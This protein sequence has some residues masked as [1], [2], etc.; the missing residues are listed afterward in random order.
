MSAAQKTGAEQLADLARDVEAAVAGLGANAPTFQVSLF[1]RVGDTAPKVATW[2]WDEIVEKTRRPAVRAE[3]DGALFS[4]AI[5]KKLYR[6][7]KNVEAISILQLDY[8][9]GS[10]IERDCAVWQK[11][12]ITFAVYSTHSSRRAL[13]DNPDAEE[14][15][16]VVIPLA[17]P[18]PAAK[19]RALW[20]WADRMSGNKLDGSRKDEAGMFYLPAIASEGA[21][22]THEVRAG[23]LLDWR[24]MELDKLA[25]GGGRSAEKAA[26]LK[27]GQ[28]YNARSDVFEKSRALLEQ[29]NWSLFRADDLGELW[30]RP[31]V[32]DHCSARLFSDGLFYVFSSNAPP[33]AAGETY[34]PFAVRAELKHGGDYSAAA[35]ALGGEGYGERR[36]A[37]ANAPPEE[38]PEWLD[39]APDWQGSKPAGKPKEAKADDPAAFGPGFYGSLK[40]L[41]A[42]ETV[43]AEDLMIGVRRRQV[44]IFASV[45]SVGKSTIM[46][47][48]ALA[49]AGG[50]RWLPL[51]PEAPQKPLKIV[52]VDA[53]STD[54]ELKKD[55]MTMLRS[56]GNREIA[57][58]NFIP[59]V[60]AQIDGEPLDLS[61]RKHFEQVKRFLKYHQPDIA[62]LDTISA[63]FT[64]YSEN[65][66]A[67][68]VRKIIRPLKEL[69]NAGN[70]AIWA[71]HH[72]GKSGES[73]EAEKAYR[74]R[75]A[76]AFGANVRGVINLTK[77]KVL[78]DGYVK[79]ELGKSKGNKIEPVIL[80]L[81][82]GRRTFD[83]CAPREEAAV[84]RRTNY[85]Q[86]IGIFNG[87][88]LKTK[89][90]KEQL[91]G[92]ISG[93]AIDEILK[94]A[95][96]HGDLF[97]PKTGVYQK[98][99]NPT[100]QT[101]HSL[102]EPG[103]SGKL[104]QT[105]DDEE[106][107][108]SQLDWGKNESWEVSD[109]DFDP[110]LEAL[111]R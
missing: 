60:D 1:D 90:I 100:S 39:D 86:V 88:P 82:F 107:N 53:E 30:S 104:A 81:D 73:D 7:N 35:K 79:L 26:G 9:H 55:T 29:H 63:L 80:K 24:E 36:E 94:I 46:L 25:R 34:T 38:P 57:I 17:I 67:E 69:A 11:Q 68:V 106:L 47:N 14:R 59:V 61:K 54:D 31:G 18:I 84:E 50:Q 45:T 74:G 12:G 8:D 58:E 22:Y 96:T 15:F 77:E 105:T 71:S 10:T 95:V 27:P 87:Q 93:S 56:I 64:L 20:H 83:L 110:T 65:D 62:I 103:K 37:R 4:G 75:G 99:E 40:E 32:T 42:K 5:Y 3:K 19:Y 49:A 108:T 101:S 16:R 72:I 51:L 98:P 70:C 21:P 97:K 89:E 102:I 76:S 6:A 28:D 43:P 52:F 44:T 13:K 109:E 33:F 23:A 92:K 41:H 78:G 66:N 85:Q 91:T 111:D 48:H 2:T